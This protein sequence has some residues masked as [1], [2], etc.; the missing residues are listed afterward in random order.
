[1]VWVSTNGKRLVE[2]VNEEPVMMPRGD[3]P[4]T[5]SLDPRG[6]AISFVSYASRPKQTGRMAY[7]HSGAGILALEELA[8]DDIKDLTFELGIDH[9]G[10]KGPGAIMEILG[11]EMEAQVFPPLSAPK[12]DPHQYLKNLYAN[13]KGTNSMLAGALR[14]P[15]WVPA[16][17]NTP[18]PFAA[19]ISGYTLVPYT[20]KYLLQLI[21]LGAGRMGLTLD[22][23]QEVCAQALRST[24]RSHEG[25]QGRALMWYVLSAVSNSY[26]YETDYMVFNDGNTQ[27]VES[28]D[29]LRQRK[30]GD[31]EDVGTHAHK[32]A[33]CM[34][35][36]RALGAFGRMIR[37]FTP[38][39]FL[40]AVTQPSAGTGVK[41]EED[42]SKYGGHL[43][44]GMVPTKAWKSI[45]AGVPTPLIEGIVVIEGTG[46]AFGLPILDNADHARLKAH[47]KIVS[48]TPGLGSFPHEIPME[49]PYPEHRSAFYRGVYRVQYGSD[50]WT[51]GASV[52]DLDKGFRG[53]TWEQFLY[54]E[55]ALDIL[56]DSPSDI[57]HS[58]IAM[59]NLVPEPT[60]EYMPYVPPP[61]PRVEGKSTATFY[62]PKGT[63]PPPVPRMEGMQ[64][65]HEDLGAG[66]IQTRIAYPL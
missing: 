38:V 48:M 61:V 20:D 62:I 47:K 64:V 4:V 10:L 49:S 16:E 3:E 43:W 66:Q 7:G 8:K 21:E 26:Q 45:E 29:L 18:L 32:I 13:E 2:G 39:S 53:V 65:E 12:F 42:P 54:G 33:R 19:F 46:V 11:V 17:M 36:S 37:K 9:R 63:T 1:M 23:A 6:S 22:E 51:T 15:F 57:Q 40:G 59:E 35:N 5:I 30:C 55:I 52:V 58:I 44:F 14:A 56:E 50:M 34:I 24:W 60:P 41:G 28:F 25:R 27:L 31:C